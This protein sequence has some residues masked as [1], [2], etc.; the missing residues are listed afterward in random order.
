MKKFFSGLVLL[1]A[2]IALASCEDDLFDGGNKYTY[3][4][5]EV[6][7][8]VGGNTMATRA[9]G[10]R[11]VVAPSNVYDL[12]AQ[13]GEMQVTLV[14]TVISLDD[15]C[16]DA[17]MGTRGTPVYTEN[18]AN[19]YS[20]FQGTAYDG[21]TTWG[22]GTQTFTG[23]NGVYSYQYD[24]SYTWPKDGLLFFFDAVAGEGVADLAHNSS[25]G[26]IS[27]SYTSPEAAADQKDILFTSR[28]LTEDDQK[29]GNNSIL[30][31]HAL[32]GVKFK[33]TNDVTY[34]PEDEPC[35]LIINS[36][37]I[38][39]LYS[40]GDCTINP[41]YKEGSWGTTS[42]PIKDDKSNKQTKSA[43]CTQW[44]NKSD[45]KDFTLEFPTNTDGTN[46]IVNYAD[47]TQ[48][49]AD[50]FSSGECESA[51]KNLNDAAYSQ[52]FWFIPQTLTAD[53]TLTVNFT[54][55]YGDGKEYTATRTISFPA[56]N[57]P[58]NSG[59]DWKAGELRTFSLTLSQVLVDID[60]DMLITREGAK[61]EEVWYKGANGEMTTAP[62]TRGDTKANVTTYNVGTAPEYQ[63]VIVTA[64]W[65]Y[66]NDEYNQGD[67]IVRDHDLTKDTGWQAVIDT[68]HWTLG[69]DGYYYYYKPIKPGCT[70]EFPLIKKGYGYTCPDEAPFPGTH[71]EMT[72]CVQAIQ[73]IA[74]TD[75]PT[76]LFKENWG[77]ETIA[78]TIKGNAIE[79]TENK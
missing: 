22:G 47:A 75:D 61:E 78:N 54:I 20:S 79:G 11:T 41:F 32:T 40:Q 2:V 12:P 68:E 26:T 77:Q 7:V 76:S 15:A 56:T 21:S 5:N 44:S 59:T 8:K 3:G 17:V 34:G 49:F 36:V 28:Y 14:E 42:N 72:L 64:N 46:K 48:D 67:I 23:S 43:E 70:P 13:N 27:F 9:E 62:V 55:K 51:N 30:F 4:K 52:T 58:G 60:D 73:Y 6:V 33:L 66:P 57:V 1:T 16:Y 37:T 19:N 29:S 69:T 39:D 71:L 38:N 18:F 10:A 63:R 74:G 31:Y 24:E 50:S 25:D 35:T 45:Q 65:V 53:N